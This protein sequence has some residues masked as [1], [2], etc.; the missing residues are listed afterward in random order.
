MPVACQSREAARS[1]ERANPS[2]SAIKA[3][4]PTRAVVFISPNGGIRK[5]AL[6][7]APVG[8]CNRRGFSAEK[9]IPPSP[10][11]RI[12][13]LAVVILFIIYLYHL[14]SVIQ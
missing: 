14:S 9:R 12:A 11:K 7:K 13:I 5:A 4:A 3:T 2:F 6:G 1:A 8:P 10:Q